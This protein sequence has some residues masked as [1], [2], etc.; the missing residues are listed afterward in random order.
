MQAV[1]IVVK[2]LKGEAKLM[3]RKKGVGEDPPTQTAPKPAAPPARPAPAPAPI[4]LV[5]DRATAAAQA[6]GEPVVAGMPGK[7]IRVAVKVG[8]A[9]AE[10]DLLVVHEH[11]MS[12]HETRAPRAGKIS[13]VAVHQGDQVDFDSLL[14]KLA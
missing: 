3:V 13:A 14:V 11:L 12:R 10:G 5:T 8:Q 7:V 9:V 6:A 1:Q 4:K 2:R